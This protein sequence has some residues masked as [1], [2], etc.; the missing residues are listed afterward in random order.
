MSG[1][2]CFDTFRH[3]HSTFV[4]HF[5]IVPREAP[6]IYHMTLFGH[7]SGELPQCAHIFLNVETVIHEIIVTLGSTPYRPSLLLQLFISVGH[8]AAICQTAHSSC[9]NKP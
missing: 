1:V 4:H 2:Y 8:C 6:Q 7:F 3:G 9:L 5:P